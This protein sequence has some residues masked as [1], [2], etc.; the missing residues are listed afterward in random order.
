MMRQYLYLIVFISALSGAVAQTYNFRTYSIEHGL[1]QSQVYDFCQ[2][3]AGNIW[4]STYSSGITIYNGIT[5]KY[6]SMADGLPSDYVVS[7]LA[8]SDGKIWIGTTEGLCVYDGEKIKII[9]DKKGMLLG[10]TIWDICEDKEKNI[11][12]GTNHGLWVY[13]K[14]ELVGFEELSKEVIYLI[15]CNSKNEIWMH[16]SKKGI[17]CY[18]NKKFDYSRFDELDNEITND[19]FEDSKGNFWLGTSKG[20]FLEKNGKTTRYSTED[21]LL[22]NNAYSVVEDKKGRIWVGTFGGGLSLFTGNGFKNFT[23]ENGLAFNKVNRLFIDDQNNLWIGTD[24][25]GASILKGHSFAHVP[26]SKAHSKVLVMSVL[27]RENGEVWLG[28]EGNGVLKI[29]EKEGVIITQKDGL[30]DNTAN[31]IF[32]DRDHNIWIASDEGLNK[33]VN[34]KIT[35]FRFNEKLKGIT[36]MS[37]VQD[38]SGTLW[39]G[40]NGEGLYYLNDT[41][42][43]QY[44]HRFLNDNAVWD[45]YYS[46]NGSLIIA[47]EDGLGILKND[48]L[49]LFKKDDGLINNSIWTI[50]EDEDN[51]LWLGTNMGISRFDGKKFRNYTINEGLASNT[52]Y[53]LTFDQQG[54]LWVGTEKGADKIKFSRKGDILWKKHYGKNQGFVSIECNS[55][56]VAIDNSGK[57]WFGTIDGVI[58][59][60]PVESA[61]N[62]IPPKTMITNV[63][64]FY[65]N[66]R[67]SNYSDEKT[68]WNKIPGHISLPY[69][70]NTITIEFA[71]VNFSSPENVRYKYMLEGFDTDWAPVTSKNYERYSN[72][73][74]GDYTFKLLACNEDGIWTKEPVTFSFTVNPPF[75][76]TLWFYITCILI[77][78]LIVYVYTRLRI[79]S[80]EK[81]KQNLSRIVRERTYEIVTQKEEIE[82]KRRQLEIAYKDI[83]DSVKYAQRIQKAILPDPKLLEDYFPESFLILKPKDYVSGDFY[84]FTRKNDTYVI[85]AIDCTGHGVPG[86]FMS[87]IGHEILDSI[88]KENHITKPSAILNILDRKIMSILH[89][90]DS[91]QYTKDGMDLAICS[92]DKNNETI[93]FSGSYRPLLLIRQ[94][95]LTEIKGDKYT[96]GGYS[97]EEKQ[98]TNHQ[99]KYEK[100]DCIYLF[101]DGYVDQFGGAEGLKFMTRRFKK[102]LL[103]INHLKMSEQKENLRRIFAEWKGSYEQVDDILIIGIRIT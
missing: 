71:A 92:I 3:P 29:G 32:E 99:M 72:L 87:L 86:A 47:T 49:R 45:L 24:G 60:D 4:I 101:S 30:T 69:N 16:A 34:G 57:I 84:W 10:T 94:G 75:W 43:R 97:K 79:R 66:I 54:Y 5:S 13:R 59:H 36:V 83:T 2:D 89:H 93:D 80:L 98:Y 22:I 26:F 44:S 56:A 9:N 21:G 51:N 46:R 18:H 35:A 58:M 55:N 50:C 1:S 91:N 12:I 6:L 38:T 33:I 7:L 42:C 48:R 39:L 14:G 90:S 53:I 82:E 40:T 78:V 76:K 74:P 11:W 20:L 73:P 61:D 25:G 37:I 67:W 17:I 100:G 103:E 27:C 63:K 68:S 62:K 95:K 8:S 77:G 102:T 28:S 64:L 41:A 85:A 65:E 52:I 23:E 88:V 31:C 19:F 96:A 70:Q 81:S 15:Y